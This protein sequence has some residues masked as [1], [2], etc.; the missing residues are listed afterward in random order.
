MD[1]PCMVGTGGWAPCLCAGQPA[2]GAL[3]AVVA[4]ARGGPPAPDA[5]WH[6][7]RQAPGR[8][9]HPGRGT[10]AAARAAVRHRRLWSEPPAGAPIRA[11]GSAAEVPPC[12]DGPLQRPVKM[13]KTIKWVQRQGPPHMQVPPLR[14]ATGRPASPLVRWRLLEALYAYA[15]VRPAPTTEPLPLAAPKVTCLSNAPCTPRLENV[16]SRY[17]PL[18]VQMLRLYNGEWSTDAAGAAAL[19]LGAAPFMG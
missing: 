9:R 10:G 5:P 7:A 13:G 19:L 12:V 3:A 17:L 15:L 18:P 14:T 2:G 1:L 8:C 6:A 16:G 4:P 11:G